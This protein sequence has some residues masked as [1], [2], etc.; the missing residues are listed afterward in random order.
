MVSKDLIVS[1][2]SSILD[3]MKLIDRNQKGVIFVVDDDLAFINV[4][5]D[6]DIRRAIMSGIPVTENVRAIGTPD[7]VVGSVSNTEYDN[8]KLLND[9]IKIIP[10]L[11]KSGKVAE[12]MSIS[13]PLKHPVS[14]PNIG[15]KE[16]DYLIEAFTSSWISS[17]GR[18]IDQFE[19]EFANYCGTSHGVACS[20]GTS[21]LHLALIACG[22]GPGDEVI[23]PNFTFAATINA[24]IHAGAI[25]VIAGVSGS[26]HSLTI[27]TIEPCLSSK[28]RAIIVVHIYGLPAPVE[29][30]G[31][32]CKSKNILL[33]EDC[34]EAHGAEI[35]NRKVGSFGEVGTFSFYANKI[36]TTGEGGMCV[37][38]NKEIADKIRVYRDHGMSR[39][40]RYWHEVVGYNYR[41]TNLQA[42]IGVAQLESITE[43]ISNRRK[44]FNLYTHSFLN[45]YI[46]FFGSG[47]DGSVV[48]LVSGMFK[49]KSDKDKIINRLDEYGIETRPC[50]YPLSAMD[51]YRDFDSTDSK[52]TSHLVS[53]LGISLPTYS[54]L[55][56]Y[57]GLAESLNQAGNLE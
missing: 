34:A 2:Y 7:S 12:Y 42:A 28:T 45:N 1:H 52:D 29:E 11:D 47:D 57:Q 18:Y 25:P 6:G 16:I 14:H 41:M 53:G 54:D 27:E 8:R 26:S 55:S 23:V 46:D 30:I 50:F 38:N 19:N 3:A 15:G 5:T 22:I 31:L 48:W 51:I 32:F 17:S 49:L 13:D 21:A 24:V 39:T 9:E 56:R 4:L 10:I 35:N 20:N 36:I 44:Y 37:T 33:I 40:R 43:I